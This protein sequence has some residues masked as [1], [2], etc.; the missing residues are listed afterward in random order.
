MRRSL[1]TIAL[2]CGWGCLVPPDG[3]APGLSLPPMLAR[4]DIS[5]RLGIQIVSAGDEPTLLG[6]EAILDGRC[7]S[8]SVRVPGITDPDSDR[9]L[10]RLVANNETSEAKVID[11]DPERTDEDGRIPPYGI[12]FD[13]LEPY[14]EMMLRAARLGAEGGTMSLFITDADAWATPA[15]GEAPEGDFRQTIPA[16]A[17]LVRVD[18][19]IFFTKDEAGACPS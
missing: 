14:R 13:P 4:E 12:V 15:L 10:L 9:L 8:V 11:D 18:W 1:L 2:A 17:N 6:G 19:F 3:Q 5:P 7:E 16:G